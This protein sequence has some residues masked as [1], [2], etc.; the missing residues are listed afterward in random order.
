MPRSWL[1]PASSLVESLP[2]TLPGLL[3]AVRVTDHAARL[4]SSSSAGIGPADGGPAVAQLCSTALGCLEPATARQVLPI[5]A[6]RVTLD[7]PAEPLGPG[8]LRALEHLLGEC[9]ALAVEVLDNEDE[10]L[11]PEQ[12]IRI[13]RVVDVL[14]RARRHCLGGAS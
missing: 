10:P 11:D 3:A 12:V 1:A 13:S 8:H 5:P 6:H 9:M 2:P 7:L 4:L 14:A